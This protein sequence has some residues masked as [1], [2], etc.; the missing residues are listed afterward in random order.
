MC[1]RRRGYT[2]TEVLVVM[3]ISA[4]IILASTSLFHVVK[5]MDRVNSGD[6][7]ERSVWEVASAVSGDLHRADSILETDF[8]NVVLREGTKRIVWRSSAHGLTRRE[9]KKVITWKIKGGAR[10]S[11]LE[12]VP[13]TVKVDFVRFRVHIFV[14]V[15]GG[16]K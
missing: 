8:R 11:R 4:L 14:S 5:M 13:G 10:F 3:G 15:N 7:G 6:P 2:L 1:N 9:G 12:S 16:V